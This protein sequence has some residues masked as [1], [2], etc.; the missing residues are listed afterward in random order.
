MSEHA[1][2]VAR[3]RPQREPEPSTLRSVPPMP[4]RRPR[5]PFVILITMVLVGGVVG[6]LLFNTSMQQASFA[7]SQLEDQAAT[8]RAQEQTLTMRVQRLRDPQRVAERALGLG[9]VSAP[10]PAFLRLSD[11]A[12]IGDPVP[13]PADTDLRINPLPQPLP[14]ALQPDRVPVNSAGD[15]GRGSADQGRAQGRNDLT[16]EG[17]TGHASS[18]ASAQQPARR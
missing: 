5:V 1:A 9:M 7:A 16:T 13:A 18:T 4:R 10:S 12:I 2:A 6:L 3:P 11:G 17:R 15:T 8:L 14:P